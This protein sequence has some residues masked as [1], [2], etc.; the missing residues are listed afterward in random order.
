[1]KKCSLLIIQLIFLGF[2]ISAKGI[3]VD[4]EK[5]WATEYQP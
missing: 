2:T 3:H 4:V 1:M 5:V